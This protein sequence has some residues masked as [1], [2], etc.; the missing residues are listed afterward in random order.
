MNNTVYYIE[1]SFFMVYKMTI[2]HAM[3][4]DTSV[5]TLPLKCQMM[6]FAYRHVLQ[7]STLY[8]AITFLKYHWMLLRAIWWKC[9]WCLVKVIIITFRTFTIP[10]HKI[11]ILLW[12]CAFPFGFWS[13]TKGLQPPGTSIAQL[14]TFSPTKHLQTSL[15][16][17][18]NPHLKSKV[19]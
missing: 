5:L 11:C 16:Q 1:G 7:V 8:S 18:P 17:S 15:S 6:Q 12:F 10:L 2:L 9:A 13:T 3:S 4:T 19:S 14:I